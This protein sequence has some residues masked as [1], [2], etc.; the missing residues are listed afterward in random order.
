MAM[1]S[2]KMDTDGLDAHSTI[3]KELMF[4]CYMKLVAYVGGSSLLIIS[5][6]AIHNCS[7]SLVKF[8]H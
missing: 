4:I 3:N 2:R 7:R 6:I 1:I 8:Q 5:V